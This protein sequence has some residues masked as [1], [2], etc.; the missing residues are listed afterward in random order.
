MLKH[1]LR[2]IEFLIVLFIIISNVY[3]IDINSNGVQ[4]PYGLISSGLGTM[5]DYTENSFNISGGTKKGSNLF[6]SF[7]KFNF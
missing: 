3:A 5:V 4:H 6:H 7:E 2:N 1:A